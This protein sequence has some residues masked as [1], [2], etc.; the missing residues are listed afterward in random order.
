[1]AKMIVLDLDETLLHTDKTISLFSEEILQKACDRGIK[2]VFATARPIRATIEYQK[3]VRCDA[4]ICHNGTVTL[5]EG[6]KI[7][8]CQGV[9]IEDAIKILNTLQ[10]KYP[11]KKLSI[12][13]NDMIYANFDVSV[14][15]GKTDKDR[16]MLKT[17]TVHT[18]FSDLP[19]FNADKV[20]VE[21]D[22]ETEYQEIQDIL[23]PNLYA[24]LSDGGKLCIIMNKSATKFNAIKQLAVLWN[25]PISQITAFGDDYNDIEM[26]LN[27]GVG[28]AMK[29]AIA[30]VLQVADIVTDSNNEDGV[31]K[32]I[33]DKIL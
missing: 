1:M 16:E 5:S 4:V 10:K 29:N 28:V 14:F 11:N 22:S 7:G 23:T 19:N 25:I 8:N 17:S 9:P 31:A 12:E 6:K 30:E 24:Q 2:I 13:I 26:I 18:D 21:V 3:Q 27:C 33:M 20:L 15:W 32:Y